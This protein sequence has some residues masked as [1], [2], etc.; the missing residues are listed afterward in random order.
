VADV[1]DVAGILGGAI[2]FFLFGHGFL[3]MINLSPA[4]RLPAKP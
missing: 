3:P 4:Y 1:D 2:E